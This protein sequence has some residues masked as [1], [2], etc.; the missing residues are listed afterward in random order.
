LINKKEFYTPNNPISGKLNQNDLK[1]KSVR[2]IELE[3]QQIETK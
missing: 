2:A 3:L 1:N